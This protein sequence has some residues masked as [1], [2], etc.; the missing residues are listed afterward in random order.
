MDITI[1]QFSPSGNTA[2]VAGGI[3]DALRLLPGTRVQL[4]D[5][6]G[7]ELFFSPGGIGRFL[8][9]RISRHDLLLIAAP[10]YAHH[11][12][13]HMKDLLSALPRPDGKTVLMP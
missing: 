2:M 4:V 3:A 11:L 6:T 8:E 10:V 1:I 13:Y 5:I 12:Q 7:D 9:S